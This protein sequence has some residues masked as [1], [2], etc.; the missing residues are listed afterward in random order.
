KYY[1]TCSGTVMI[2]VGFNPFIVNQIYGVF[3]DHAIESYYATKAQTNDSLISSMATDIQHPPN[4]SLNLC[5]AG[6]RCYDTGFKV[7]SVLQLASIVSA[8]TLFLVHMSNG[9]WMIQDR[10][11]EEQRRR[12]KNL[13]SCDS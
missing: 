4:D 1:G 2:L 12:Q 9:K 10:D 3:Y 6:A 5:L 7:A 8:G 13:D 11:D